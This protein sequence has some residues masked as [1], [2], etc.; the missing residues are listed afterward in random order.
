MYQVPSQI[1]NQIAEY[2][3]YPLWLKET[4]TFN[5]SDLDRALVEMQERLGNAGISERVARLAPVYAP[6]AIASSAIES[7]ISDNDR[8]DLYYAMPT[9]DA[10]YIAEL[11]GQEHR[12]EDDQIR[13]LITVIRM[14]AVY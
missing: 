14:L 12:L 3:E 7:F 5:D 2:V 9:G 6:Y 1:W 13:E 10:E 8:L 11:V 4:M